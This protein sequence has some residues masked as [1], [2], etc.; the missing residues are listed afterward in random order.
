MHLTTTGTV[1][2]ERLDAGHGTARCR[3]RPTSAGL[4]EIQRS[5]GV[6]MGDEQGRRFRK[7]MSCALVALL[8]AAFL[9]APPA[10]PIAAAMP[11]TTAYTGPYFG[12]VENSDIRLWEETVQVVCYQTFAEYR[13][14]YRFVNTG[15]AQQVY[16]GFP[17]S[18]F[19]FGAWQDGEA[20][21][22]YEGNLGA[23]ASSDRFTLFDVGFP[24]GETMLTFSYVAQPHSDPRFQ[25]AASEAFFVPSHGEY[26][27]YLLHYGWPWRG[28]VHK[29]VIRYELADSFAGSPVGDTAGTA[30]EGADGAVLASRPGSLRKIDD[31][32][33]Q[34][35]LEDFEP[36]TRDDVVFAY[37]SPELDSSS[38][39]RAASG[40]VGARTYDS[41]E[42]GNALDRDL[43]TGWSWQTDQTAW[44]EVDVRGDRDLEE[45]R[46]LPGEN[47]EKDDFYSLGRPRSIKVEL[48]DGTSTVI[49]LEDQPTLQRFAIS[50]E[51]EWVRFEVLDIYPGVRYRDVATI[52][53]IDLGSEPSPAMHPFSQ[54]ILE[55]WTDV[56]PPG[57]PPDHSRSTLYG[58]GILATPSGA[59]SPI[60][61]HAVETE[62][63]VGEF[64]DGPGTA[65]IIYVV[66]IV[67]AVLVL[68]AAVVALTVY[69]RRR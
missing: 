57:D 59:P 10:Q 33:F 36:S 23:P 69:F 67:F 4:V 50:G 5:R 20:I 7:W 51:A 62:R 55:E 22:V 29:A 42:P 52:S 65:W 44:L 13:A 18:P 24:P 61:I 21:E 31:R 58:P 34:W 3:Y 68:I 56:S 2:V 49:T 28:T 40:S 11:T 39:L 8:A 16:V 37:L 1:L 53:E 66:V 63:A 27:E 43:R 12:P 60:G 15:A 17:G 54:L 47:Y 64:F 6:I 26:Y 48:S 38:V 9:M 35:I 32:T 19:A 30:V 14:D 45:I 46:I 41:G 25:R